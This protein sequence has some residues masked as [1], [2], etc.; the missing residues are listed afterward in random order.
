MDMK[1]M[2]LLSEWS[3]E[4]AK[5]HRGYAGET[6]YVGL[7]NKDGN[8][9]F[10]KRPVSEDMIEKFTGGR[11]FGLKLLW[12]AVKETTKWD[13]PENELVIAGGPFCGITQY[14]GTGKSYT[15][16]LSP[17]T[18][19]TYNSNAGGYFGPFLKF[20]GFDALE[21]QGKADRPVVVFIDGDNYKVQ[22][23]ESTLE[24]NNAYYISEELH[25]YF[26]K[27]EQDKRTISVISTGMAA[28]TS[29][30]VG[31]NFS[32]YDV[33]RKAVRLKQAGR[34]GGGTVLCDKNVAAIVVKRTKFTG[35]ENDPVDVETIMKAGVSLHKRIHDHDNEQCKMRSAGTA[36]LTEIM[37]D[38]ELLPVNNYKFGSHKDINNISSHEYIKLFSQGMADGC[39]YGCSLACAKAVDHFPLQ[40]GPWKGKEVVVDG[41]EY[42]TAAGLGSNVGVFDPYWT[43]E[44]NF[45]A[46]HYGFDTISLGTTLAWACECY[47]LGL[48]N[49]EHTH[50]LEVTFGNKKDLMELI[51][52]MAKASDD[53]AVAT[54]WGIEA[55]REYYAKHYGADLGV[56]KKI[57][58]VCQG[59]EASE[60]R[61]Q[62]SMA[63][64]GGYFL[65][66]KGPQHDEAWLIFMDMVNK[67]LPTY[68]D[69]AEALYFFPCFRLWFSLHGLCKLPWNDI[70]PIDNSIKYKGIEAARVPE[71]LNNYLTIYTAI[72]GKPLDRDGMILQSEKV[73]NFERIFNL[74]MGKGTSKFHEAPDRGLGPVW[75]DEWMARPDYFDA[76]LK[77]F[78]EEIEGK[79]VKEKIELLQKHRRSQWAQLKAAV[80][81]RRGWNKNGIPTMKTVKRLGIDYPEVVA[82][83]EK[84][85]KPE[86]EFEDA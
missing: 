86:D 11:G 70:E 26:A 42:E 35:L 13:D 61:C 50:G 66:L 25:D 59:L 10:E 39:W 20:S 55:A 81:K 28:K 5:I 85:L 34:G 29:Y 21:I 36:H 54:G 72:T 67:Q 31:L 63:Q 4:P 80:Y 83:L 24:D 76:K 37:D 14:P 18:K 27:D 9:K 23:F 60:Y 58:M 49:K 68:E 77:E 32:F 41:P 38:Y 69:K 17:A 82:L 16:F 65:T 22:V 74:R 46:D 12:D 53:F 33:R 73:Y 64:W 3:Y 52:R 2:K 7:G 15:V 62:E 19:Q 71:H 8:Y 75:E 43:I 44:A 56:M 30:I 1:E 47:E 84:H 78:G 51:H 40:T 57:G 79:S 45:Y 48:I 6:L